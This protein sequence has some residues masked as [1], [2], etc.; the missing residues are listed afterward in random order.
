MGLWY[1]AYYCGPNTQ[2]G[3]CMGDCNSDK[4]CK[5]GLQCFERTGLGKAEVPGCVGIAGGNGQHDYGGKDYCVEVHPSPRRRNRRRRRDRRRRDRRRRDRRRRRR[6]DRRRRVGGDG[7][8][9]VALYENGDEYCTTRAKCKMCEGD[10]DSDSDC[11]NGLKCW[12]R[13]WSEPV[14]NCAIGGKHD[15]RDTDYCF[16]PFTKELKYPRECSASKPCGQ[17]E[18]D[19]DYDNHCRFGFRCYHRTAWQEIPG[20]LN[21]GTEDHYNYDY[22]VSNVVPK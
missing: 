16:K 13:T 10:C 5:K 9:N 19:C 12:H 18:G 21:E 2:C 1:N 11:T 20:C 7:G 17:C 15:Y 3:K 4:D 22:C 8:A 14:P 6:R